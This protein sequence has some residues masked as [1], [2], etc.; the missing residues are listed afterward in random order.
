M[1]FGKNQIIAHLDRIFPGLLILGKG[2]QERYTPLFQVDFWH[3]QTLQHLI[4]VCPNPHQL[5]QIT[6][7]QL[8]QVYGVSG[9]YGGQPFF[10]L[11]LALVFKL[12]L[13]P[14]RDL[15]L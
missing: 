5:I 2:A 13:P 6:P 14:H 12:G 3:C 15:N 4:R 9:R 1:S 11:R 10:S 7:E 8:V